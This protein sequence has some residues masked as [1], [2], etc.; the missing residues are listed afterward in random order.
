MFEI[1]P[2]QGPSAESRA[3]VETLSV[4]TPKYGEQR[5][6]AE[7]DKRLVRMKQSKFSLVHSPG[8]FNTLLTLTD[9]G[10]PCC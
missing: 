2:L 5:L 3:K 7:P 9:A 10:R 8:R 6:D 1:W 4:N